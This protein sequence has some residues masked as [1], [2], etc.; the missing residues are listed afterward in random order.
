MLCL[1]CRD[2][3]Y[4]DCVSL[5]SDMYLEGKAGLDLFQEFS[6]VFWMSLG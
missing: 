5:R 2:Q 4:Q 3:E 6:Q 1:L